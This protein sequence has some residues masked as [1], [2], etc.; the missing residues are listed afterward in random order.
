M[1]G[2][3]RILDIWC[4]GELMPHIE[5]MSA[6]G[7]TL[8]GNDRRCH[9][10]GARPDAVCDRSAGELVEH[11]FPSGLPRLV[12]GAQVVLGTGNPALDAALILDSAF[13]RLDHVEDTDIL[14]VNDESVSAS[15]A[16]C[17][18][19]PACLYQG[20]DD[21]REIVSSDL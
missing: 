17:G 11:G 8:P 7:S 13:G 5:R 3:E 4:I 19:D 16:R 14:E 6:T 20:G 2:Y 15:W 21:L 1:S 12:E 9:D 18:F 10:I